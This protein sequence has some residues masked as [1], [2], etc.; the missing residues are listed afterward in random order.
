MWGEV[1]PAE[2]ELSFR[3]GQLRSLRN[4][5]RVPRSRAR[6]CCDGSEC[7]RIC[8][9]VAGVAAHHKKCGHRQTSQAGQLTVTMDCRQTHTGYSR[10]PITAVRSTP[11]SWRLHA[12]S[13]TDFLSCTRSELKR[14]TGKDRKPAYKLL[15]WPSSHR[16]TTPCSRTCRDVPDRSYV[17]GLRQRLDWTRSI[18]AR[19]GRPPRKIVHWAY[20]PASHRYDTLPRRD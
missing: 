18:S 14:C 15:L 2:L 12:I 7:G 5:S 19:F 10:L 3:C 6:V 9:Q 13:R 1:V 20:R 16:H 17:S 4:D 11:H 8:G